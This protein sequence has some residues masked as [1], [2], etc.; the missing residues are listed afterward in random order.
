MDTAFLE[1][2]GLTKTEAKIYLAVLDQGSALAGTV[3]QKSG[4]HR[5]SVYDALERLI[6]KGLISFIIRNN[7]KWFEAVEPSRLLQIAEQKKANIKQVL[8]ELELK[9]NSSQEKQEAVFFKGK[10]GLKSVFDDQIQ[11]KRTIYV[12]GAYE[13]ASE[14]IQFYFMH[15]DKK[16]KA[17]RIPVKMIFPEAS[18]SSKMI[19]NIPLSE[20]RFLP[21]KY[22]NPVGINVY[23]EKVA[24]IVWA[25]EPLAIL[26]NNNQVAEAYKKY[27]N[28]MWERAK[29]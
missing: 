25:D 23:G 17:A 15:Y 22:M 5:R 8:P 24:T 4:I 14:V 3:S 9:F 10:Q 11:E 6:E 2:I 27:F 1:D 13:G 29:K 28:F 18:R 12:M 26:I 16:R 21:E 20:I 19:K 7:R